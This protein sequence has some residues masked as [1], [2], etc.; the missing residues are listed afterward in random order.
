VY[1][2]FGNHTSPSHNK[3]LLLILNI[4]VYEEYIDAHYT[5]FLHLN[6]SSATKIEKIFASYAF[7]EGWAHYCEAKM[8][9][10]GY[11]NNGDP[12]RAAKYRLAQSGDALLRVCRL[13]VPVKTHN[14][15]VSVDSAT[16][17]F[18]DNWHQG[19]KPSQLENLKL[20]EDY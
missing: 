17:F 9:D 4:S 16:K 7:V 15:G 1:Q 10:Q 2:P 18:I 13:C 14:V 3:T 5:Q 20:R 6:A 12:I 19:E 8:L 11:G